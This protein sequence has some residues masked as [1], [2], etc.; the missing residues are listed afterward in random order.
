MNYHQQGRRLRG[1]ARSIVIYYLRPGRRRR[2]QQHYRRFIPPGS[3]VF[4][5]G[6]HVGDRSRAFAALGARV[7]AIEPQDGPRRIL[8]FALRNRPDAV[9][10]GRAVG[11]VDGMT[12]LHT[13]PTNPT[14]AS[15][16]TEWVHRASELPGWNSYPF[17]ATTSVEQVRLD[18]LIEEYGMPRFV[19]IDVEGSE[20][21]VLAGLSVPLNS[22]SFEFLPADRDVTFHC[23]LRLET[24]AAAV[25]GVYRYNFS[26]GEELR[27]VMPD[28]WWTV[29]ELRA[30]LSEIPPDG[31]SGDVYARYTPAETPA[32]S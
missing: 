19:K 4:D 8:R 9:I 23:L 18:R 13:A 32:T 25:G 3:L 11:A 16:S 27:L 31:P 5:I 21:D 24:L 14:I 22:L 15:T 26:L 10:D 29:D 17:T 6:A 30:Y 2:L 12:T 7:V 20:A 1:L 28:T